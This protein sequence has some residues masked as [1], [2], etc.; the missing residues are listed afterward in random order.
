[1]HNRPARF[2]SESEY[3]LLWNGLEL[4]QLT[5]MCIPDQF[6]KHFKFAFTTDDEGLRY[7]MLHDEEFWLTEQLVL[8]R[9]SDHQQSLLNSEDSYGPIVGLNQAKRLRES[10]EISV[11]AL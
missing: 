6:W 7:R 3:T 9:N 2:V 1:M 5:D 10:G 8:R 4:G 11:R